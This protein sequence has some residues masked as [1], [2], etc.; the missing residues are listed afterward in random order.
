MS[1]LENSLNTKTNINYLIKSINIINQHTFNNN[2]KIHKVKRN[3]GLICYKKQKKIKLK[4]Q[5]ANN[6]ILV[7]IL[8]N[9][10]LKKVPI[11]ILIKT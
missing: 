3:I 7:L 1:I 9:D 5:I 11:K 4:H 8:I 10:K 6:L 2:H